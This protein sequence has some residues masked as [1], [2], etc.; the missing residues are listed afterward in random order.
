LRYVLTVFGYEDINFQFESDE[1]SCSSLEE[2]FEHNIH[3]VCEES[4][5]ADEEKEQV[6]ENRDIDVPFQSIQEDDRE[7]QVVLCDKQVGDNILHPMI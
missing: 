3:N 7:R 6:D 2:T 5:C 4:N 1:S